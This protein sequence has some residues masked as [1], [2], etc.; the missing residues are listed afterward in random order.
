MA[1]PIFFKFWC[2][3]SWNF[4]HM[5]VKLHFWFNIKFFEKASVKH[6]YFEKF[7][8]KK[9]R[10]L[11]FLW[12][13]QVNHISLPQNQFLMILAFF[14]GIQ[15]AYNLIFLKA[16]N[17]VLFSM[18]LLKFVNIELEPSAK[19]QNNAEYLQKFTSWWKNM[20]FSCKTR[21]KGL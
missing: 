4:W 18:K 7:L 2:F 12:F 10:N 8:C 17:Y 15:H 16:P 21:L 3:F 6:I 19:H 13:F 20:L 5:L 9:T 14:W 1:R 11:G